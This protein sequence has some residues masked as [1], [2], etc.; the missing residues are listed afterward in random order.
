[1]KNL[2]LPT[3]YSVL[4]TR[5]NP[6]A[7]G[8]ACHVFHNNT[9]GMAYV[10]DTAPAGLSAVVRQAMRSAR[11]AS[12]LLTCP[13][14]K[15]PIPNPTTKTI[16]SPYYKNGQLTVTQPQLTELKQLYNAFIARMCPNLDTWQVS[17]QA[18]C[19]TKTLS[20][21]VGAQLYQVTT[22]ITLTVS[23][24][25][26]RHT[27]QESFYYAA[28]I[29]LL[30]SQHDKI[31]AAITRL[32]EHLRRKKEAIHI[33]DSYS[34]CV[35][36]PKM[37]AKL[38]HEAFGHLAEADYVLAKA[39]LAPLYC[40]PPLSNKITIVDYAHTAFGKTVPMP[41]Y[42]DDEGVTAQDVTLIKDG[43]VNAC[44]TS[45]ETSALLGTPLT[46]NARAA[47]YQNEPLVRMRNTA[48]H[49]WH[50]D[51]AQILASIENG[52]Y[53]VDSSEDGG[54]PS[55]EFASKVSIAYK[56]KNGQIC[57]SIK[58]C[59]IWGNAVEFLRSITMV[60]NDFEWQI[61]DCTKLS[62][63]MTQKVRTTSGAPTIK[64]N[65]DIGVL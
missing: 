14:I 22:E 35:L 51:P 23:L 10:N 42:I 54:D 39:P 40:I 6:A 55:G 50:D 21:S 12:A 8:S 9:W 37:A 33:P 62:G 48:L 3:N 19:E 25:A 60:G 2:N 30:H 4:T 31:C 24:T 28:D 11:Q 38:I 52:Y 17:A 29:S 46:G 63:E 61:D 34:A 16:M 15:L 26:G 36:S 53:L 13:N 64:A 58:D 5:I 65:L 45:L 59:V 20:S 56:V 32:Y 1:M 49:P 57:E 43:Q 44:M 27:L 7:S 41:M 47:T 18:G